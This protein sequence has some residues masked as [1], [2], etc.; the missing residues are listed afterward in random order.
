MPPPDSWGPNHCMAAETP[1]T[2]WLKPAAAAAADMAAA[3]AAG[4]VLSGI[5]L[6]TPLQSC[7]MSHC[8]QAQRTRCWLHSGGRS[9]VV[10]TS[11]P[12]FISTQSCMAADD[13]AINGTVVLATTPQALTWAHFAEACTHPPLQVTHCPQF[14]HGIPS[15]DHTHQLCTTVPSFCAT[16]QVP[17]AA[18]VRHAHRRSRKPTTSNAVAPCRTNG[19]A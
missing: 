1:H 8:V 13:R 10:L 19:K 18:C 9:H 2:Q 11:L 6:W 14:G 4:A 15:R 7:L 3:Q 5:S 16:W 12:S 17:V